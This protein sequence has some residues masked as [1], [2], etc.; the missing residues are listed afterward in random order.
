MLFYM[1]KFL[2]VF[3]SI[4]AIASAQLPPSEWHRVVE[5]QQV[6]GAKKE[7][8]LYT[9]SWKQKDNSI[10]LSADQNVIYQTKSDDGH[11][12]WESVVTSPNQSHLAFLLNRITSVKGGGPGGSKAVYYEGIIIARRGPENRW[13]VNSVL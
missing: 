2:Y 1:N 4:S 12:S 3:L 13:E 9:L 6:V 11:F 10:T 7:L 5:N 8:D